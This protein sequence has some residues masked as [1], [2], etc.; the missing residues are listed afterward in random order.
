VA[1]ARGGGFGEGS[2]AAGPSGSAG[3]ASA[4]GPEFA[5]TWSTA[6]VP[7]EVYDSAESS[8]QHRPYLAAQD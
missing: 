7:E 3:S 4:G 8:Q 1:E 2:G 6:G 5:T